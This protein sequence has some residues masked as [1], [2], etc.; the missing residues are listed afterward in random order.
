[1]Q[2]TGANGT[3]TSTNARLHVVA[4]TISPVLLAGYASANS[5]LLSF[6][7]KMGASATTVGNY[8][9][10][11]SAG[12]SF[13]ATGA[14]LQDGTNVVLTFASLPAAQYY[15]VVNNV[16]D[17]S[18]AG[19]LIAAN[20]IIKTGFDDTVRTYGDSWRYDQ[21]GI[22]LGTAWTARTYDDSAWSG[23]GPGLLD[24]KAGGRVASTLPFPV[25]TVILAPTNGSVYLTN[26]YFRTHFTS[27]ASGTGTLTFTTVIDDGGVIY[28]NGA[29]V[30]RIRMNSGTVNYTTFA[31]ASVGDAALEGP[32]VVTVTNLLAGD[33]VI[34][35]EVHQN[36]TGSSDVTW[37][38]EF[39]IFVPSS[40][41]VFI[42]P[43]PACT[44]IALVLPTLRS[45]RVNGTNTL[46]SWSNPATNTCGSNAVFTL[47]QTL[48]LSNPASASRWTNVTAVSPYTAIGTN[49]RFFRLKL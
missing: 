8:L 13:S 22:S 44:N 24:G 35:V 30:S 20:S 40:I 43:P 36:A 23:S 18:A 10:T 7:E 48:S 41:P 12:A 9:V 28:L 37:G 27:Y 2:V 46:L 17:A 1:V 6:S 11:N 29:E 32:F 25:G 45:Q 42:P 49:T 31:N 4:D 26:T 47:Q 3:L 38:G 39:S 14:T 5:I 19:N 21:R 16:R 15:V 34:A 33:N